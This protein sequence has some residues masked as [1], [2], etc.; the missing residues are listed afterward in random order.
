[1]ALLRQQKF[2]TAKS[3]TTSQTVTVTLTVLGAAQ[4]GN[5]LKVDF[6]AV[7]GS[8]TLSITSIQDNNGTNLTV[9]QQHPGTFAGASGIGGSALLSG[10][11]NASTSVTM[12][13]ATTISSVFSLDVMLYEL[14]GAVTS[15]ALAFATTGNSTSFSFAYTTAAASEFASG[16]FTNNNSSAVMTATN[17]W[18]ID[19]QPSIGNT[20]AAFAHLDGAATGATSFDGTV[21]PTTAWQWSIAT[22]NGA[23]GVADGHTAAG[24]TVA[25]GTGGAAMGS[26][27][28]GQQ[29][30]VLFMA[31][32]ATAQTCTC[33]DQLGN[34]YTQIDHLDRTALSSREFYRF[35]A[36]C[37]VPGI[38][39]ITC[40]YGA[41]S[42]LNI[43]AAP[44]TG[45]STTIPFTGGMVAN[46]FQSAASIGGSPAAD[47]QS[48]TNTP[49]LSFLPTTLAVWGYCDGKNAAPTT[50]TAFTAFGTPVWASLGTACLRYETEVYNSTTAVSGR[51]TPVASQDAYT[52][53]AAFNE[54]GAL[55][56]LA[57]R[58]AC[59]ADSGATSVLFQ[60]GSFG[61]ATLP[62]STIFVVC[63]GSSLGGN[64]FTS[65]ADS[66][67]G[68]YQ[69]LDSVADASTNFK[70][71]VFQNAAAVGIA[72]AF[73]VNASVSQ[74][75]LG[76][77]AYEIQGTSPAS[78]AAHA[79]ALQ[80]LATLT[81]NAI[82][83]G[84]VQA[85]VGSAIAIGVAINA[86]GNNGV[87][88]QAAIGTGFTVAPS[89]GG[90]FWSAFGA[91]QAT[92]EFQAYTN[93]GGISATFTAG[94]ASSDDYVSFIAVFNSIGGAFV[95]PFTQNQFFVNDQYIQM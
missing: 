3:T 56:P 69:A 51:F 75:H 54:I 10:L 59:V 1:M 88:S 73:T 32:S 78:L 87:S 76:F 64:Q 4:L 95:P 38:P 60:N 90:A 5:S 14:I 48:S 28:A 57:L 35:G 58:Q 23:P 34:V 15:D 13:V 41:S 6:S 18:T 92:G 91:L 85:G 22:L 36:M 21:A 24:T 50:G 81:A 93:P 66:V 53:I 52:F 77:V 17:G 29:I 70:A 74:A 47:L 55:A 7:A 61:L 27:S 30:D 8:G 26:V 9:L 25:T 44:L 37:T 45:I 84:Q 63:K 33:A 65:F 12:V 62:G 72:Q 94:G 2:G 89:P 71:F 20:G 31:Q 42:N 19:E 82:T 80:T 67:N 49:T 43:A 46:H 86:T 16:A 83:T 68:N 11:T 79:V 39:V 40:T